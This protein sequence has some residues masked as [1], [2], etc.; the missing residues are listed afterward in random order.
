MNKIYF[1]W[2][3]GGAHLKVARLERSGEVSAVRQIACPLWQGLERLPQA[4]AALDF[5]I[6]G[7][8]TVHAITMTAEL[9]DIFS[10]RADGVRRILQRF[11]PLLG[12]GA[13]VHIYGGSAGWLDAESAG[14]AAAAVASANWLALAT[15]VAEFVPDA[16][17]LDV[18]STTTDVILI[19]DGAVACRGHDDATRLAC[20]ELVYS[21]VVRTPVMAVASR[22]PYDGVWQ[23]LAAEHFATMADVY[24]VLGLLDERHDLLPAADG[25]AKDAAGSARRLARMLGRDYHPHA[26][27]A[28]QLVARY[29]ADRQRATLADAI[30]L[31]LSRGAAAAGRRPLIG[32]GAG[33]FIAA[34][35]ARGAELDFRSFAVLV[36]ADPERAVDIALAAPA[37]AVARLAWMNA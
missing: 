4:V 23:A 28:L 7:A 10:D 8:H 31:Q 6:R 37:V 19:C 14:A 25:G 17:L 11:L 3:I 13:D 26:H 15:Y 36:D 20:G 32:A 9:C 18:G 29:F 22:A 33:N 2:D 1:G 12:A 5:A 24:R 27:P 21:G 35:L 34:D 16:L 30:A